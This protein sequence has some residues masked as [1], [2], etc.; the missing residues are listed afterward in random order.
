[1]RL[2]AAKIKNLPA[3]KHSDG[4]NGLRLKVTKSGAKSWIQRL[5]VDGKRIERGLGSYP[6]VSLREA[7]RKAVDN[8][9]RG[10]EVTPPVVT[11]PVVT[12]PATLRSEVESWHRENRRRYSSERAWLNWLRR[13]ELHV[14]A[15]LL[16]SP[17]DEITP[18]HLLDV[19]MPLTLDKAETSKRVRHS[20]SQVFRRAR[21]YGRCGDNPTE[22]LTI[23]L[24]TP[25]RPKHQRAVHYSEVSDVLRQVDASNVYAGTKQVFRFMVLCAARPGEARNAEWSEVKDGLWTISADKMKSER[26]HRVPL[27]THA[28]E[29]LT[30]ARYLSYESPFI[31]P[32]MYERG[33]VQ[34]QSTMLNALK[35]LGIPSSAHGFRSCFKTWATSE[36]SAS[37]AAIELSLA[38]TVG[39]AVEQAYMRGDLL[40]Q[41]KGLIQDWGDYLAA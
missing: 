2:T 37:W 9:S 38:H 22:D 17:I 12:P 21:L 10:F 3:G 7:R 16:D 41:R 13:I 34:S 28:Q 25:A 30:G 35:G 23:A 27:S 29:V 36:T 1:M 33:N 18:G 19:L 15:D 4:A 20:L 40:E 6:A 31:F 26:E 8:K 32:S 24:P 14:P 39:G 5:T 11:P